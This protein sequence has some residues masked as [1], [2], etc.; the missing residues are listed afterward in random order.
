MLRPSELHIASRFRRWLRTCPLEVSFNAAFEQ[1]LDGCAG[2]RFGQQGTWIT[3]E[4]AAAYTALHRAGWAHSVDVWNGDELV[5]GLYGLAIG[6][7]FFG[8]SMFSRT[9][10]ASKVAMRALCREL[11]R[12]E[13]RLLDCQV[14]SPHLLTLGAVELPR[15][16]FRAELEIACASPA[17]CSDWPR[18]RI[19]AAEPALD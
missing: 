4:M 10:N 8:E 6:K 3:A 16:E 18:G 13:F 17:P 12:R 11:V 14:A 19:R 1:V 15:A 7:A 9:T 5:G 2:L